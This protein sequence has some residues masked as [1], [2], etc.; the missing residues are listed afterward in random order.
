[1]ESRRNILKSAMSAL[2]V[3]IILPS[4]K[5]VSA[6]NKIE[7]KENDHPVGPTR[8]CITWR[9]NIFCQF[10]HADLKAAIEKCAIETDCTI[11]YGD[12]DL[13][14]YSCLSCFCYDCG[15]VRRWL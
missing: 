10:D 1:M 9:R 3:G 8:S 12:N 6:A 7:E 13:F 11:F 14:G 2:S 4:A 5:L 15:Q